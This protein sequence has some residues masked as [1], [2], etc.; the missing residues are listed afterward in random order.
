MLIKNEAVTAELAKIE[1]QVHPN[2]K[3]HVFFH[4]NGKI[5]CET[6]YGMYLSELNET[7]FFFQ[8]KPSNPQH[9]A[10]CIAYDDLLNQLKSTHINL[11]K[12]AIPCV[13]KRISHKM[14]PLFKVK[15]NTITKSISPLNK[16]RTIYPVQFNGIKGESVDLFVIDTDYCVASETHYKASNN[17]NY[18]IPAS[19][20]NVMKDCDDEEF[21]VFEVDGTLSFQNQNKTFT[22]PIV[23]HQNVKSKSVDYSRMDMPKS[24]NANRRRLLSALEDQNETTTI[25]F[26]ASGLTVRGRAFIVGSH[27]NI[28]DSFVVKIKTSLL[29]NALKILNDEFVSIYAGDGVMAFAGIKDFAKCFF[30]KAEYA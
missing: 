7:D 21:N 6:E 20:Y 3:T 8:S 18:Q 27:S 19:I 2:K 16:N 15:S 10:F 29:I 11:N 17:F 9:N 5:Y 1:P 12:D 22:F 14:S 23:F 28:N 13:A 25:D 4:T 24:I 30:L 26:Y